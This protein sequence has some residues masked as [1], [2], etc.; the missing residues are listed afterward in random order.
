MQLR[1][2]CLPDSKSQQRGKMAKALLDKKRKEL[3]AA[4]ALA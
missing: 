4:S 3:E 2:N 1:F